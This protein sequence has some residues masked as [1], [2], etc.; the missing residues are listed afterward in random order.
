M[1][2]EVIH[3]INSKSKRVAI[4]GCGQ[5]ARMMALAG[6]PM[7]ISF[8]FLAEPQDDPAPVKDLGYIL[9]ADHQE[10]NAQELYLL[11]GKPDV[12]TIDKE[13]VSVRL[14]KQLN[15]FC[16]VY[17]SPQAI[18]ICQNRKLEKTLLNKLGLETAKW[19]PADN[20]EAI[21][22][23]GMDIGWPL[24]IKS[25]QTTSQGKSQWLI[26]NS[27]AIYELT[28][29]LKP[30]HSYIAEQ[31]VAF[32][33]EL[34]LISGRDIYGNIKHYDIAENFHPAGVLLS[35][36]A[37]A[38][39]LQP[40]LIEQAQQA[41]EAILKKI[42]YVGILAIEFFQIG[43]ALLI[44]ELIPRVHNSGHWTQIAC[45]NSQFTNHVRTIIGLPIGNTSATAP[46]SMVN[47][48]GVPVNQE[49]LQDESLQLHW[50]NKE[51]QENQKVGHINLSHP[52][53]HSLTAKTQQ[54]IA[55]LYQPQDNQL[56]AS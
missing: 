3:F 2:H 52:N 25:C 4:I 32:D 51:M 35:S 26:N 19:Q 49:I 8:S 48:L 42:D 22:H 24:V 16:K 50:Y 41:A 9:K 21:A 29:E 12:I 45:Q 53:A 10:Y 13:N 1:N 17:P 31:L 44:N 15:Q 14:L 28:H 55:D 5:L 27:K 36:I 54:L 7:G 37:P 56:K 46:A 40:Q 20:V 11:L 6:M 23:A 38:D 47:L 39:H 33:R 43:D 34:S 18:E 30:Q